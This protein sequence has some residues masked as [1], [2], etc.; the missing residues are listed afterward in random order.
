MAQE[1]LL[2]NVVNTSKFF[3]SIKKNEVVPE[4]KNEAVAE[5][6]NA[7]S[8]KQDIPAFKSF[9]FPGF[10]WKCLC[11]KKF[12]WK[13]NTKILGCPVCGLIIRGNI[14]SEGILETEISIGSVFKSKLR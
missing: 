4:N 6:K 14:N 10:R 7:Y 9:E 11:G 8:A 13:K 12:E 5:N 2:T 3:S 1:E